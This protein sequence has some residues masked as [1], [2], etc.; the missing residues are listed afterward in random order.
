MDLVKEIPWQRQT[1]LPAGRIG[2]NSVGQFFLNG[3]MRA[4]SGGDHRLATAVIECTL[5]Q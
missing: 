3:G 1:T 4:T 5:V 2:A